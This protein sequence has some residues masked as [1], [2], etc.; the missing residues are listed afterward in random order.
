MEK[1]KVRCPS[2]G[3]DISSVLASKGGKAIAKR[4]KRYMSELGKKSAAKR[5]GIEKK[6]EPSRDV[7][8]GHIEVA[9]PES[10]GDEECECHK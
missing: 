9:V 7:S 5:W 2:C 10:C 1:V 6:N 4:G 8:R 3:T